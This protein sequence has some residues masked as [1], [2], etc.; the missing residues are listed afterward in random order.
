MTK[1]EEVQEMLSR[2]MALYPDSLCYGG[3]DGDE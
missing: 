2:L 3:L 1:L